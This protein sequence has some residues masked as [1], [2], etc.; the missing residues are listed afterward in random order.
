MII[1]GGFL[2]VYNNNNIHVYIVHTYT[3]QPSV[4]LLNSI[5]FVF[6]NIIVQ[7]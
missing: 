7:C 6:G 5:V 4:L 2:P 1:D 3:V